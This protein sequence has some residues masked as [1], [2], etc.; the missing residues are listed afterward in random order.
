MKYRLFFEDT[1]LTE[2]QMQNLAWQVE[3]AYVPGYDI[4][5][6]WAAKYYDKKLVTRRIIG[7]SYGDE[8]PDCEYIQQV[9]KEFCL[10]G[11]TNISE[12]HF[13]TIDDE[14]RYNTYIVSPG[15]TKRVFSSSLTYNE[16]TAEIEEF[17]G[18][19]CDENGFV[20]RLEMDEVD[21]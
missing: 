21:E 20:W 12:T 14:P 17:N 5:I 10:T 8:Q 2:E 4:T 16:A 7:Y 19:Y 18:E 13:I 11:A 3:T 1:I 6:I 15:G 9:F